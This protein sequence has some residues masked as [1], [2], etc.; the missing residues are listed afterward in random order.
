[1]VVDGGGSSSE[2]GSN[3][4]A[5]TKGERV[6]GPPITRRTVWLA[7]LSLAAIGA[8]GLAATYTRR[9]DTVRYGTVIGALGALRTALP[10]VEKKYGLKYDL[11]DFRDATST[12][13]AL[14]QGELDLTN[15][16][17]QHLV[18]AISEGIDVV[19]IAG[20]GGGYNVLVARNGFDAPMADDAALRAAILARKQQG[21][22]VT[23]GVPT[24]SM[25][26]AKL[27]FYLKSLGMD[28]ERDTQI[29]NIPFPNHPRAL[30]AGEVDM[31]MT[32]CVF[33][34]IAIDKGDAKLVRH[35]YGDESGKQEIGFIVTRKLTRDKPE[36]V[37]HIVSSLVEAMDTFMD[38]TDLRIELE[39]KYS[40]LPD[41][42]IAMQERQ[43]LKYNYRTNVADLKAM[44]KELRD[45]GWV[46]EDYADRVDKYIDLTFLAKAT[47]QSPA[48]L[49][50]W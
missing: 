17:S 27:S 48:Q 50:T 7:S 45:L 4:R 38:N 5:A 46:K 37:Q 13:L 32:L 26:H 11:K 21:K 49:S 22:P 15:A 34:A 24:G 39:R 41:A 31:A 8:G 29:V 36:L 18:R 40:R 30:E 23:I 33:G 2:E 35:L 25:Q 6:T 1:M 19:W 42:V 43:F 12:L 14:D 44:A 10:S 3:E 9:D 20:W 16:T 47:G 28:G